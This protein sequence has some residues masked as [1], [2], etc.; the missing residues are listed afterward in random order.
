[1]LTAQHH[2]PEHTSESAPPGA[3]H[4]P[5]PVHTVDVQC[6]GYGLTQHLKVM[7]PVFGTGSRTEALVEL[8]GINSDLGLTAHD[9]RTLAQALWAA[10]DAADRVV[11]GQDAHPA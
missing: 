2:P 11:S 9:A 10:A 7:M 5:P 1:M 8:V 6:T 4:E 3:N